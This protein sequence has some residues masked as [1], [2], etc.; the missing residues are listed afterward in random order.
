M[1]KE[2]MEKIDGL[3]SWYLEEKKF[4]IKQVVLIIDSKI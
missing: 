1:G 2:K 4:T 3:I